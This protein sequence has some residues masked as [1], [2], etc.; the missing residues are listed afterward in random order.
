MGHWTR[1]CSRDQVMYGGPQDLASHRRLG[2][3]DQM[4]ICQMLPWWIQKRNHPIN[5]LDIAMNINP[6]VFYIN[7]LLINLY[8]N[9]GYLIFY[10][11]DHPVM[12]NTTT[13]FSRW[14]TLFGGPST[15][16]RG[17]VS[18]LRHSGIDEHGRIEPS[19][20]DLFLTCKLCWE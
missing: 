7:Y 5:I 15:V 17:L 18:S 16:R 11:L 4:M 1:L 13:M 10:I 6:C 2:R 8:F 14:L 3:P 19:S 12:V 20:L 9:Y